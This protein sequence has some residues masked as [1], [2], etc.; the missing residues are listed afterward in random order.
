MHPTSHIFQYPKVTPVATSGP[1]AAKPA[2]APSASQA[3]PPQ[4]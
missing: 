1:G 2:P 4:R 3:Q